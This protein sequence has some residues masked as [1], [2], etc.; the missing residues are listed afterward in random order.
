MNIDYVFSFLI[1]K[2]TKKVL[3]S[4]VYTKY[5]HPVGVNLIYN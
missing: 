2:I 4:T 1:S 3:S 5:S